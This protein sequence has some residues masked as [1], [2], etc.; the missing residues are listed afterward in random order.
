MGG[1]VDETVGALQAQGHRGNFTPPI[2]YCDK[3]KAVLGVGDTILAWWG[4]TAPKGFG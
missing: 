4:H 1:W 3:V 2:F